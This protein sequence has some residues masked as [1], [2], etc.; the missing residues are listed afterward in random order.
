MER[1]HKGKDGEMSKKEQERSEREEWVAVG[2][3]KCMRG[4][5]YMQG[6]TTMKNRRGNKEGTQ[7]NVLKSAERSIGGEKKE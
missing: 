2:G 4:H 3:M 6:V 7:N 1:E 5:E